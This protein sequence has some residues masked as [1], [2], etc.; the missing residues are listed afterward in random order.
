MPLAAPWDC[1]WVLILITQILDWSNFS[2]QDSG[3]VSDRQFN[4]AVC[5]TFWEILLQLMQLY[6]S[7]VAAPGCGCAGR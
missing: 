1:G 7:S 3:F 5:S 4:S 6:C 2:S